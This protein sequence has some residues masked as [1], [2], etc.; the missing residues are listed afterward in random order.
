MTLIAVCTA[1]LA[2]RF[3]PA[4]D[5]AKLK[6]AKTELAT[7]ITIARASAIRRNATSQVAIS[8][9]SVSV[10]VDVNGTQTNFR[11]ATDL[12]KNFGVTFSGT[13]PATITFDPRGFLSSTSTAKYVLVRGTATDS[14][15]VTSLGI[16]AQV[17]KG[18]AL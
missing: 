2:P 4:F 12:S 16:V 15:C 17:A 3:Q 8:G 5:S 6:S 11:R 9:T 1:M 7:Y 10:T 14:V 18:C 13:P